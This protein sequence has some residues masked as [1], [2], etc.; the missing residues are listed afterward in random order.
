[1]HVQEKA[2]LEAKKAVEKQALQYAVAL[3]AA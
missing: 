3:K 2:E 1:M